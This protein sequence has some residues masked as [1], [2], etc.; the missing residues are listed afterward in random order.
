[1]VTQH[2]SLVRP[3]T[4]AEN[5]ILGRAGGVRLD[6]DVGAPAGRDASERYGISVDPDAIVGRPLGR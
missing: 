1:M 6:L 2:F 3:M 5:L 4:V